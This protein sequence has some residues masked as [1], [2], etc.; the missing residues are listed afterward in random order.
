MIPYLT[1]DHVSAI[2]D[3]G[4]ASAA[5]FA[6]WQGIKSLEVWRS[7]R[8]GS[9]K[10][11]LAEEALL[12]LYEVQ[13]ALRAIRSPFGYVGEA[14]GRNAVDGES[15]RQKHHRDIAYIAFERANAQQEHFDKLHLLALRVK[16]VFGEEYA[17]PLEKARQTIDTIRISAHTLMAAPYEGFDDQEFVRQLEGDVWAM[18]S[19]DLEEGRIGWTI[20]Q[21]VTEGERLL[22]ANL[23]RSVKKD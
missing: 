15:N 18:G 17:T 5:I 10:I 22:G 20:S 11:E 12:G 9:R 16:A 4:V 2:S 14:D 7:E 3:V 6:A 8:I 13:N 1:V 19:K 23:N 21:S